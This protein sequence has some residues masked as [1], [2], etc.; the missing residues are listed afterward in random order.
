MGAIARL[1]ESVP[2]WCMSTMLRIGDSKVVDKVIDRESLLAMRQEDVSSL[3]LN[4]IQL[5]ERIVFSNNFKDIEQKTS[6]MNVIPELLSRL[7]SK[8][9]AHEKR[10]VFKLLD[11]IYK[12][13]EKTGYS[14]VSKLTQ[15]LLESLSEN[16]IFNYLADLVQFPIGDADNSLQKHR[17]PNPFNFTGKINEKLLQ[18]PSTFS[19]DALKINELIK[20]VENGSGGQRKWCIQIL[21]ELKRFGVLSANQISAFIHGV[22]TSVDPQG[23]PVDTLFYKFAFCH[24]MSPESIEGDLLI[25]KYILNEEFQAQGQKQQSGVA[26]TGGHV[27]L[28]SEILGASGFVSWTTDEAHL[29]FNKLLCWWNSDKELLDKYQSGD[30]REELELRFKQLRLA[31]IKAVPKTFS[32]AREQDVS[33]LINMVSEMTQ[34]GL[35]VCSIKCSFSYIVPSW[36]D[37]LISDISMAYLDTK[38]TYIEDAMKGMYY[39]FEI[40]IEDTEDSVVTDCLDLLANSLL[41][42]DK[43]RLL[44]S[45]R[46]AFVIASKYRYCYQ[47]PFEA[48]VL[49]ALDKLK[50]ETDGTS[51]LFTLHDSLY[52]R[53]ISAKLAY[54]LYRYY[55]DLELEVPEVIYQW[56]TI[57]ENPD[58]F[59]EIRNAWILLGSE[60]KTI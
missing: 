43:H 1:S 50:T 32:S 35:A 34:Y 36:K 42:R 51:D 48:A 44:S 31:L 5:F 26:M 46:A 37:N 21:D 8:C 15:R 40:K 41:R 19:L 18:I 3:T 53:E 47:K 57:C 54:Q 12:S 17:F 16:D 11:K 33:S 29:I 27:P 60:V 28:C 22:W 9:S 30:I 56:R 55:Q 38:K 39:F 20:A 14:S 6:L 45:L 25:K 4:Y 10:L 24:D 49:F 13:N 2:Y 23:F 7:L 59:I 52:I 58:E